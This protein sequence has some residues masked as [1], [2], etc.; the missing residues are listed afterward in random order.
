MPWE[1]VSLAI[2]VAAL[3]LAARRSPSTQ[4]HGVLAGVVLVLAAVHMINAIAPL[5]HSALFLNARFFERLAGAGLL[6]VAARTLWRLRHPLETLMLTVAIGWAACSVGA[7]I[8]RLDLVSGWLLLHWLLALGGLAMYF[9]APRSLGAD[10]LLVPLSLAIGFSG[11]VAQWHTARELSWVSAFLGGFALLAIALRPLSREGS[12]QS[13]RALA[14][15]SAPILVA[16]WAARA[17]RLTFDPHW[18]MPMAVTAAFVLFV[19]LLGYRAKNR[20]EDWFSEATRIFSLGFAFVL[21]ASS[22]FDIERQVSAV[23]LELTSVAALVLIASW[24]DERVRDGHWIVPATVIGIALVLQANL[25]RWLGPAGELNALDVTR[26][27]WPTLVSLLWASIGAALTIW[28]RRVGSRV[29]WSAGAAFLVGAAIKLLLLDFGS[30]GQLANI[31]A[32]I[33][34]GGVFLLVGWLAPM[35][36]SREKPP[37]VAA[38]TP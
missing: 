23:L 22:A 13:G 11:L 26:M 14:A 4:L 31:L 7:E 17:E 25:L 32:V 18:Q 29:Q 24:N 21:A 34:A 27:D 9:V 5:H 15:L 16:I 20:S 6:F 30:L 10:R 37:A 1:L 19:L 12:S 38:P 35:P 33:A 28:A 3:A 36:P 8:V 2:A